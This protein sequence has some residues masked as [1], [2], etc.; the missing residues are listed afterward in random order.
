M[1]RRDLWKP[2]VAAPAMSAAAQAQTQKATAGLPPLKIKDFKVISTSGG[3]NYRWTFLKLITNEPGLYGIG[4]AGNHFQT[5]AVIAALEK[6]LG[7][8]IIGKDPDRIEDLWQSAHYRTYWRN[9][10]VNNNA[11]SAMDM[12]LWD[13]KGKRANMPVYEL[14]G[15]KARD[16][17]PC[18]DHAAG[19]DKESAVASV[20]QSIAKGF[21]HIRVQYGEGG[22]GGG[23]FIPKGQGNRPEGG[24]QDLA[25]DEEMYVE[26]IPKIFEYVRSKVGTEP[27]LCHDVHSHLSGI[28]AVELSRRLQ[29]YQ[30][31]FLEDV[32]A[33][34]QIQWYRQIRQICTTPQAVGEVF[35]HPYEFFPLVT[36]RLIDF[37]RC[38]VSA[39]GGITPIKK[40]ATLCEF[41]G[42]KTAFQ[43]GGENDP[44]NQLA[45]YHIDISS[46]AFGIQEENS[47]P[48]VVH[49]M[50]P[51][52]AEIRKG[53]LYG[54]GK[55][56]LGIDIN[57]QMAAKYPLGQIRD[58]GAYRT[59]R[60][61]DGAVVR[62]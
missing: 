60:T 1:K 19:R 54:N 57:E 41:F 48:P 17:V 42:V 50:M 22:Y 15:G 25:F 52:V 29:S 37:V 56:G 13:I 33:P 32:L 55:P 24:Q 28:N 21:R 2:F 10:P 49:E 16:A 58:G 38:R 26:A 9:G 4:T 40:I 23:G 34:E 5:H 43:E 59:D 61:L 27:K 36:E 53:Y 47:F 18:Y 6:H 8:W 39:T 7:P 14:L 35:S 62:P 12:A 11:L 3:R 30:L 31:L 45:A 20:Q 51:G 44:V 46:T